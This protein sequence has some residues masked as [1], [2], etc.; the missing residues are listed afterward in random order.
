[1]LAERLAL[2]HF[3]HTKSGPL[4][5]RFGHPWSKFF[6]VVDSCGCFT[7]F[8][9]FFYVFQLHLFVS[10]LHSRF[11]TMA[12]AVMVVWAVTVLM[13][14][15]SALLPQATATATFGR[16]RTSSRWDTSRLH[17]VAQTLK[18]ICWWVV[19]LF[20][21]ITDDLAANL[22]RCKP[23]QKLGPA[24]LQGFLS[25]SGSSWQTCHRYRSSQYMCSPKINWIMTKLAFCFSSRTA[26]LSV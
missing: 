22:C 7:S 21:M 13:S 12:P 14:T 1:M 6:K 11:T 19:F 5:E 15:T 9:V 3:H 16:T 25:E 17:S 18:R 2:T 4:C 10:L 8:H 23:S 20:F 24:C 26:S